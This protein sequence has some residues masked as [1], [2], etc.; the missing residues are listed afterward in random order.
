MVKKGNATRGLPR[1]GLRQCTAFV[2]RD[3]IGFVALDFVLRIVAG[4]VVRVA[5]PVKIA[6]VNFSDR[7][8]DVAGFRVPAYVIANLEMF[9]HAKLSM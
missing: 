5:L 7:P 6:L 2:N 8:A 1:L 4:S 9:T 3:M